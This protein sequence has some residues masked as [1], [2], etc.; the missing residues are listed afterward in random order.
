[1]RDPASLR[2]QQAAD[3]L[4]DIGIMGHA[5]VVVLRLLGGIARGLWEEPSREIQQ[6]HEHLYH[7]LETDLEAHHERSSL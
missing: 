3:D 1:M 5:G 6:D 7:E 4:L 2:T